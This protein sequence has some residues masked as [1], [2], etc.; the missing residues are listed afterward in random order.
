MPV[1]ILDF[2][3]VIWNWHFESFFIDLPRDFDHVICGGIVAVGFGDARLFWPWFW[4]LF[5][6]LHMNI[7]KYNQ[8]SWIF[9]CS[10]S[11]YRQRKRLL[12]FSK[13]GLLLYRGM[14]P[15]G[16]RQAAEN[17]CSLCFQNFSDAVSGNWTNASRLAKSAGVIFELL[18]WGH[19]F[20]ETPLTIGCQ[21]PRKT[22]YILACSF[23]R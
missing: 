7:D 16:S 19:N 1:C 14:L 17:T 4:V 22:I 18:N 23:P 13:I 8:D 20:S 6:G 9:V 15:M 21:I 10:Y 5:V 2:F 12:G 3:S 11:L